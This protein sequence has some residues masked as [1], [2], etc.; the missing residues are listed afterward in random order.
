MATKVGPDHVS[1]RQDLDKELA[2]LTGI[3]DALLCCQES[4][5]A[6]ILQAHC[7]R[8]IEKLKAAID[9]WVVPVS[10]LPCE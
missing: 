2:Y 10:N 1:Y 3:I 4:E 5:M 8:S 7:R 6:G 9:T